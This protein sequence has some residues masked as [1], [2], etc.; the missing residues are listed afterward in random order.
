MTY[1]GSEI[2]GSPATIEGRTLTAL[3]NIHCVSAFLLSSQKPPGEV[4]CV[5]PIVQIQKPRPRQ[6]EE[7]A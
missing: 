6:I 1:E 2:L 7:L 5:V 3:L 4:S